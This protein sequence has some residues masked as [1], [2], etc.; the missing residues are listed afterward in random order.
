MDEAPFAVY[1]VRKGDAYP[2]DPA[3]G[4][5]P[6]VTL[7]PIPCP[8]SP[9]PPPAVRFLHPPSCRKIASENTGFFLTE[10]EVR[11]PGPFASSA[12]TGGNP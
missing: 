11:R 12:S 8:L 4:A 2:T 5:Y 6:P 9:V 7:V 1:G 3:E 10:R